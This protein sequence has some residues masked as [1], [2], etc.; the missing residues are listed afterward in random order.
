MVAV[1]VNV[2]VGAIV[3]T[4]ITVGGRVWVGSGVVV[5]TVTIGVTGRGEGEGVA[6]T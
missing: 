2:T 4:G 6:V 5:T 1:D 3:N